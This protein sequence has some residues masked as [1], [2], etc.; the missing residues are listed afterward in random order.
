MDDLLTQSN[1]FIDE[2]VN[3]MV[4]VSFALKKYDNSDL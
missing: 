3:A 4:E 1:G 2:N